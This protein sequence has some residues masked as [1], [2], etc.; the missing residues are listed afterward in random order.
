MKQKDPRH[1]GSH[2]KVYF[3]NEANIEKT[4]DQALKVH[5]EDRE[6]ILV[7]SEEDARA[8][9]DMVYLG[10]LAHYMP[11]RSTEDV[12]Y[13]NVLKEAGIT[14]EY[15]DA[16]KNW[17]TYARKIDKATQ[18]VTRFTINGNEFYALIDKRDSLRDGS[19]VKFGIWYAAE[20]EAFIWEGEEKDHIEEE[21]GNA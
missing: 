10:W 16:V 18:A 4:K 8:L 21:N 19:A 11:N 6:F 9:N 3:A 13:D 14:S 1:A 5:S 15:D 12:I 2:A 17:K 7:Y 20:H